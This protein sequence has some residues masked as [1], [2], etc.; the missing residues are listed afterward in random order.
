MD[1]KKLSAQL[2]EAKDS[3][4]RGYTDADLDKFIQDMAMIESSGGIDTDHDV[5][6]HGMHKGSAAVGTYGF[7][8]NTIDELINRY[9]VLPEEYK[10]LTTEEYEE[11]LTPEQEKAMAYQLGHHVLKRQKGDKERGAYSWQYG[12]NLTPNRIS[13]ET[14]DTNDRVRKY[15]NLQKLLGSK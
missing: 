1:F 4:E 10:G 2:K 13:R 8:P 7:M 6:T 14:L 5:M 12:H 11:R 9:K 15:R 3:A